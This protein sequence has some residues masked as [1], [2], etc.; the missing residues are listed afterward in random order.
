VGIESRGGSYNPAGALKVRWLVLSFLAVSVAL[1]AQL[2]SGAMTQSAAQSGGTSLPSRNENATSASTDAS[3]TGNPASTI[4][5]QASGQTF[6]VNRSDTGGIPSSCLG[7]YGASDC[8]LSWAIYNANLGTFNNIRFD[9]SVSV[10]Q[11]DASLPHITGQG[12]WID[13]HTTNGNVLVDGRNIPSG[14]VFVIETSDVTISQLSINNAPTVNADIAIWSG[15]DARIAHDSLGLG[16]ITCNG[17]LTRFGGY[18]LYIQSTDGTSSPG[19]GTAYIWGN[20]IGCH[21]VHGIWL[22]GASQ[23]RIGTEPDDVTVTGNN[24]GNDGGTETAPNG[25]DGIHLTDAPGAVISNNVISANTGGGIVLMGSATVGADISGNIVG[26]AANGQDVMGNGRDG[27]AIV[28][29]P[30]DIVFN[31]NTISGNGEDGV[32]VD[33]S[34]GSI[35][36]EAKNY[37][38]LTVSGLDAAPNGRNGFTVFDDNNGRYSEIGNNAAPLSSANY[39]SGNRLWGIHFDFSMDWQVSN[40]T[41]VGVASDNSTPIGNGAVGEVSGG[42]EAD[43]STA[44][45]IRPNKV[46]NN[47]GT[48]IAVINNSREISIGQHEISNNAGLPIDLGNDGPTLNGSHACPCPNNWQNYPIITSANANSVGGTACGQCFV[49]IYQ[50]IGNPAAPG[51]G[52]AYI[53]SSRANANGDWFATLPIGMTA[54]DITMVATDSVFGN[55]SEMSP[56]STIE[57]PTPSPTLTPA[58]TATAT[59]TPAVTPTGTLKGDANCDGRITLADAFGTLSQVGGVPP[60]A[61]CASRADVDCDSDLDADDVLPILDYLAGIPRTPPTGCPAVGSSS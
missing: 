7:G 39:I 24:I 9:P 38:G 36:F 19:N 52:G 5:T 51:G 8:N 13:G 15:H 30:K 45:A 25:G 57:T 21:T 53:L 61:P 35:L 48:G 20:T 40:P 3:I 11:P 16:T 56:R 12:T 43:D 33:Q 26:L 22:N 47:G 59:P 6:V 34:G 50:A 44:L 2:T 60:G 4:H 10:I 17:G 42:I 23:V 49:D 32:F 55:S 27:I 29:G 1:C 18:G 58:P 28:S 14:D 41:L 37:V 54:S 46:S 31:S